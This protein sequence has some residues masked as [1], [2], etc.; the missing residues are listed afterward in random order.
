[1]EKYLQTP[2][3]IEVQVLGDGQGNA[4]H[5]GERDCSIQRRHQKIIEEAPAPGMS[6]KLRRQMGEAAVAAARAIGYVGAGTVEFLLDGDKTFY[7]MEMNTRLQ[8]EHPVTEMITGQDL[9]EWQLRIAAG[10]ALPLNQKQ[11]TINGHALEARIYA[12]DPQQDFLPSVGKLNFVKTPKENRHVRLDSGVAQGDQVSHYYDPMLAKLIVWDVDRKKALQ[13]LSAALANYQ[14]IGVATNLDLLAAIERQKDFAAAQFDTGFIA[15]H[16]AELLQPL[17]SSD[18]T[19]A[20]ASLYIVSRQQQNAQAQG[21]FIAAAWRLNLPAQQC[22]RFMAQGVEKNITV[23]FHGDHY[24]LLFGDKKI[25]ARI[26]STGEHELIATLNDQH[27]QATI[28]GENN[29]LHLLTAGQRQQI[30]WLDFDAIDHAPH[31]AEIKARLTAPMPSKVVAL[32]AAAGDSVKRGAS[33]AV[34]EAMKMEHT[35]HA[36]ADGIIQEWYFQVGDMVQEGVELL[37]F[38][39]EGK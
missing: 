13:R 1:M 24:L 6:A 34:V 17:A 39:E 2:R 30:T 35:I 22:L 38:T 3:H 37:A 33:L 25:Q 5:L 8:V 28:Y 10:D 19:L 18:E 36:P 21:H 15:K 14:I 32:L 16:H 11:L 4:I 27:C 23:Q 29:L 12:E 26:V 20:L 31:A 9:V 7:F